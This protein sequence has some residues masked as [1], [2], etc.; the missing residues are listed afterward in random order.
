MLVPI[1]MADNFHHDLEKYRK[2][3]KS[4]VKDVLVRVKGGRHAFDVLA[5]PLGSA[6]SDAQLLFVKDCFR[7][8]SQ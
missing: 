3:T 5:S 8:S 2:N 1:G 7:K 6:F 4:L